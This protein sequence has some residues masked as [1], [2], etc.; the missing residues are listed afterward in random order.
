M[1]KEISSQKAV[2][3]NNRLYNGYDFVQNH[4]GVLFRKQLEGTE[5][6]KKLC[7]NKGIY[8]L[9]WIPFKAVTKVVIKIKHRNA[10]RTAINLDKRL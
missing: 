10:I 4:P 6:F 8:R 2:N 1:Y 7:L 3:S 5:L 9:F